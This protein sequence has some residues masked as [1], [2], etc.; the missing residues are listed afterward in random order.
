MRPDLLADAP[1][2]IGIEKWLNPW[3]SAGVMVGT[4]VM[5]ERDLSI[6]IGITGH[7]S[8]FDSGGIIGL[9]R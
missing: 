7:T 2:Q 9:P 8:A 4:D 3:L 6:A 5:R 1:P